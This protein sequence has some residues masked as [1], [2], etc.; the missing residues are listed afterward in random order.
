MLPDLPTLRTRFAALALVLGSA[1]LVPAAVWAH[2]DT[3]D[4]PVVAAAK[5]ALEKADVTPVL[6]WIKPEAE[7]EVRELFAKALA[8]RRGGA[9]ARELA[10][11]YFFETLV[12][13]HRAGEGAPYTGLLPAG[14]PI[15]PAIVLADKSLATGDATE[16]SKAMARHVEEGIRQRFARAAETRKHADESV[17]AGR[18]YVA[19]YVEY[20]HYVERLHADATGAAHAAEATPAAE[21][22]H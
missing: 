2:C 10:D 21:H 11:R 7:P 12:R 14:T 17:G 3:M 6:K 9:A 4:G 1:L 19:A 22:G 15:E 5:L 16:L 8:A 20:T 18:E 13:I